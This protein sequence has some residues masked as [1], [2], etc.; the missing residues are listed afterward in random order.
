MWSEKGLCLMQTRAGCSSEADSGMVEATQLEI[1]SVKACTAV[2][3]RPVGCRDRFSEKH[4]RKS[5]C[6]ES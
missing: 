1:V 2:A 3:F 5:I 4:E 6:F